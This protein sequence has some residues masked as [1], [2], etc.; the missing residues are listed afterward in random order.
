VFPTSRS[1]GEGGLPALHR[2][3]PRERCPETI[4]SF[5]SWAETGAARC[6]SRFQ[7]SGL[8]SGPEAQLEPEQA[9]PG[10]EATAWASQG[11]LQQGT[12]LEAG[13]GQRL[14]EGAA[15]GRGDGSHPQAGGLLQVRPLAAQGY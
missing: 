13:V 6:C 10:Q 3:T 12:A 9:S 14:R 5:P 4:P 8:E 15:H 2:P 11:D 1:E 7:G